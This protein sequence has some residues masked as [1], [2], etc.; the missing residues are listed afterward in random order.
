[1]NELEN[2][3][4]RDYLLLLLF[5]GLRRKEAAA[6]VWADIDLAAEIIRLPAVRTKAGR[7]LDLPMSDF[8]FKLLEKRRELGDADFV[9]PAYS[10]SGHIAEPRHF[11]EMIEE[12]TDIAVTPHG[13]RRTFATAADTAGVNEPVIA[14]M[15]NHAQSTTI[16]ARYII[17]SA[18]QL[19]EPVQWTADQLMKWAKIKK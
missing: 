6:L 11:L 13:L 8:V 12:A 5:T 9:F 18:E 7:R 2:P 16:T 19:R 14:A 3:V 10:K 17:K 4:A 1:M 15:L